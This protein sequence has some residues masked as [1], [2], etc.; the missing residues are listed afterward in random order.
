MSLSGEE[1][2]IEEGVEGP[3]PSVKWK[4][5][6]ARAHSPGPSVFIRCG[7]SV[8]DAQ[9]HF[10]RRAEEACDVVIISFDEATEG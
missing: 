9:G 3:D 1:G 2:R 10:S 4:K 7:G 8:G 6:L 5:G